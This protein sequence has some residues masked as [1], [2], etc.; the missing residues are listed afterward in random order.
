MGRVLIHRLTH[1]HPPRLGRIPG[2]AGRLALSAGDQEQVP[3]GSYRVEEPHR[4]GEEVLLV[5]DSFEALLIDAIDVV[6]EDDAE[7]RQPGEPVLDR[8]DEGVLVT[9]PDP[10]EKHVTS[11]LV[12]T[13]DL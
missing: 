8:V 10:T 11:V 5:R 1:R 3:E 2:L 13:F 9:C 12:S 6:V 4:S 7:V